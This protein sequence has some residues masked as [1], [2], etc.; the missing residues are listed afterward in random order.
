MKSRRRLARTGPPVRIEMDDELLDL[1]AQAEGR[2]VFVRSDYYESIHERVSA[3]SQQQWKLLPTVRLKFN[4]YMTA[5]RRA[6]SLKGD[7]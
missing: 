3:D 5:R 2:T 1:K 4:F 7:A 6:E